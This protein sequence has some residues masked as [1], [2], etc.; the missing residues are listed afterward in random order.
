MGA[1]TDAIHQYR[2]KIETQ[3]LAALK[4]VVFDLD[5]KVV[6]RTPVGTTG[7]AQ[8]NWQPS[9]GPEP[10]AIS[11]DGATGADTSLGAVAAKLTDLR[12]GDTFWLANALPYIR[13]LEY[14]L[15]PNPPKKGTGKTVG[16]YSTQ[17]PSGMV[18]VSA[19]EFE[20]IVAES[21]A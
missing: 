16:G 11:D 15:Y 4:K 17:A 21:A 9:I 14:G 7:R 2:V 12:L 6:L 18:R 5:S 1:F 13:V 3:S 10:Q 8:G 20:Q 19:V